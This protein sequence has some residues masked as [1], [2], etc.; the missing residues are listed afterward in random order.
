MNEELKIIIKAVTD[1]ARKNIA[2]VKK[3]L[4]GVEDTS[5]EAGKQVDAAMAGMAKGTLAAIA[6]ITALSAA[7]TAL[8]KSAQEVQKGFDKLNTTFKNN[9]STTAQAS[10]TYK[11]L[12]S[13][14]GD[15]DKAIETA[16][17]IALITTEE[18]ELAKWTTTLQGA[19]AEMGDKLPIE[20]L[21]E[22]ANESANVG[23]VVGVLADALTWAGIS[24]DGFNKALAQAN[25]TEERQALI[26]NTLNGLYGNSAKL[27]SAT[28]QATIQ[29]NEAQANL[30]LKLAEASGYTTPFLTS[31]T[32][33]SSTLLTAMAPALETV[34]MY[35][36]AFIEVV[37]EAIQ[38]VGGFFGLFS[39]DTESA[40]ANT[41]AYQEAMN[42]YL[43]S[44]RNYFG[45]SN[46]ELDDSLDKINA[47]KKA[48]MGFDE[49]NIV[50]SGASA[51]TGGGGGTKKGIMP[52]APNPANY[53]IGS[54]SM[55]LSSFLSGVEEAKEKTKGLL[56]LV[57]LV[58]AGIGAWKLTNFISDILE[59]HRVWN[60]PIKELGKNWAQRV[61]DAEILHNK[62]K[63]LGGILLTVAGTMLLIAGYTDAWAN[64]VDWGN[65]A[66]MIAGV[67]TALG[68]LYIAFGKIALGIGA[69]VAAIALFVIY[70]KD[71]YENGPTWQ[72]TILLLG[73]AVAT[74]VALAT[75]GLSVLVAAIIAA[76]A[77]V[78]AF[79]AAAMLEK[80][81]ILEVEE[82]EKL[83][84]EA[85]E[86]TLAAEEALTNSRLNAINALEAA[87]E[88]ERKLAEAE[89]ASGITGA[90]LQ[91]QIDNGTLSIEKMT[92]AEREVYKAY[93]NNEQKQQEL[94]KS[95][96]EL[97]TA[98]NDLKTA[99][100][101][102]KI[103]HWENELA[104][105][106]E[107][108][109]YDEYKTAVIKAYE[110]GSLSADEAA[111]LINKSMSEM[112]N[113]SRQTFME[114][115]PGDIRNGLDPKKYETTGTKLKKFF[116]ALGK[117]IVNVFIAILNGIISAIN[118]IIWPFKAAF[119]A[120][121]G[122]FGIKI[123]GGYEFS[124][125]PTVPYLAKGGIVTSATTAVIGERGKEA[126]LP[127]ENNTEWM[128]RLADRLAARTQAPSK[129]V[130]SLDGKELGWATI[131]SMNDIT[132]Q[133]GS[134]QLVLA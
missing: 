77:A 113:E 94:K 31:I 14:L 103:A 102:E 73:A 53:G 74:A 15:H 92:E 7:M 134:L 46:S 20:G 123:K 99:K 63:R 86:A 132:K 81:A 133:T 96:E 114:D 2:A 101:N 78:G 55:D 76:V 118:A 57:G 29:Y 44:L 59:A 87:E 98:T 95:Q 110:E 93:V 108:D 52:T 85:K 12:F 121:A 109:S 70:F 67:A 4:E 120:I 72:N 126:V 130:L 27:Y 62:V 36:T 19:F 71:V 100:D 105:A 90:E 51:S 64:G 21:A 42:S 1:E 32:N 23:Q 3:E 24:E 18:E 88:A 34:S 107:S 61:E 38:W 60:T 58:A 10:Q 6:A 106:K 127:L 104:L 112:S 91:A 40:A 75:A 41:K 45:G 129:I 26:L 17:S 97:K 84:K 43:A 119:T 117:G 33:L 131:N 125:I 22:A 66:L 48:T 30:N 111:D 9:G 83:L 69:A 50:S 8:G 68:G 124:T 80:S 56:V 25:S 116:K 79:I 28:A 89:K 65:M 16:Q 5:Q 54:G 13:F 11:E 37:A 35:L 49:L 115:I 47:V 82:A 122:L 39:D 128:D